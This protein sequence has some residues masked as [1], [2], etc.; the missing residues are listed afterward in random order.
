[1]LVIKLATNVQILK[2]LLAIVVYL[3]RGKFVVL[4]FI[5]NVCSCL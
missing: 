1:M 3:A 2:M 5:C 4:V